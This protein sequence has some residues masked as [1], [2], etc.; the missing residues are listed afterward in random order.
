MQEENNFYDEESRI[1]YQRFPSE[2]NQKFINF[3]N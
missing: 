2:M 3:I 1:Y